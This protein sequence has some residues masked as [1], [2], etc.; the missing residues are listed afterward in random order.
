MVMHQPN[1]AP[2]SPP[3]RDPREHPVGGDR[4][5]RMGVTWEVHCTCRGT[6][7][8]C[9]N[10]GAWHGWGLEAWRSESWE[11]VLHVA[12]STCGHAA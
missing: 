11:R 3:D 5:V 1:A 9:T 6:V 8:A 10:G 12:P 7:V 4:L 2:N